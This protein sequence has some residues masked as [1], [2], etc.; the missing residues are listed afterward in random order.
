VQATLAAYAV[1]DAPADVLAR[2]LWSTLRTPLSPEVAASQLRAAGPVQAEPESSEPELFAPERQLRAELRAGL[3]SLSVVAPEARI[4]EL[5]F[6]FPVE[7]SRPRAADTPAAPPSARRSRPAPDN[8]LQ[9]FAPPSAG[10]AQ[11]LTARRL[12]ELFALE[13][14]TPTER[15]Y[16]A[17]LATLGFAPLTGFLRGFMDLVIEHEGRY[18]LLDYKSNHLGDHAEDY[19]PSKLQH[20]MVGHHYVLQ[21]LIYSVAL[22]RYLRRRVPD[23]DYARH[24]GGTYYLFV[25]GMSPE[26]ALGSGVFAERPSPGLIA[27]LDALLGGGA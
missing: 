5:E 7:A 8:Q 3:P 18:Y 16:A 14:R 21:A 12:T 26:H 1:T 23:Y 24:F 6:V 4:C 10:S 11:G 13:A 15:A 9:L 20:V 27:A 19:A 2:A 25:R 22:D 17:R